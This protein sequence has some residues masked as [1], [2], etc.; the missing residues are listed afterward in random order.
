MPRKSSK[1]KATV[2]KPQSIN[3]QTGSYLSK[4]ENEIQSNQSKLNMV[5]GMLIVLVVGILVFNYFNR[6]KTG[7]GPAQSTTSEQ[8]D[9]TADKLP[10]KYTV[11][12]GDT[13][14]DIANKYYN[15]GY[16][17]TEIAKVNNL[18]NPDALETGQMLDIPKL[19]ITA[20]TASPAPANLP[21]DLEANNSQDT[22]WGAKITGDSYTVQ[23][24]DWLSTIA[25][26][27]YGDIYS[28][29]KISKANN[30]TNPNNIEAGIT[31]IIPR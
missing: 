17:Y 21:T 7:L 19:E 5:L 11:K 12:D 30:I 24:G 3:L 4:I 14:F 6:G 22:T 20:V 9:V 16:K 25:G 27:A 13:L 31:L 1:L 29:E 26:R 10:G 8:T 15:D 28:Y 18:T 2:K 23:P